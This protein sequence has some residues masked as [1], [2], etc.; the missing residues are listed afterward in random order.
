M[1]PKKL[2]KEAEKKGISTEGL[3]R[4]EII[5]KLR[6]SEGYNTNKYRKKDM[7]PK[8]VKEEAQKKG[9]STEGKTIKELRKELRISEGL[10]V[11]H[12]IKKLRKELREYDGISIRDNNQDPSKADINNVLSKSGEVN[13]DI[14]NLLSFYKNSRFTFVK[15]AMDHFL[16]N[17]TKLFFS[18][19]LK[20]SM[21]LCGYSLEIFNRNDCST[22]NEE[23]P[24]EN[25][26]LCAKIFRRLN[27]K[28]PEC[29]C[30]VRPNSDRTCGVPL[31]FDLYG[32]NRTNRILV[33]TTAKKTQSDDCDE[34]VIVEGLDSFEELKKWVHFSVTKRA[35]RKGL[36]S[37]EWKDVIPSHVADYILDNCADLKWSVE[38]RITCSGD[39]V[40]GKVEFHGLS[41]EDVGVGGSIRRRRLLKNR[42]SRMC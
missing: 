23:S 8:K 13:E 11:N 20:N 28:R 42:N 38:K 16:A 22:L 9:I 4:K 14:L 26:Q 34:E 31:N 29:V 33:K 32:K 37:I 7:K 21:C 5:R 3:K 2:K 17:D 1:K 10:H 19:N 25:I 35:Q 30:P 24:E 18:N 39:I 12:Q 6:E 36:N 41:Y 27:G 40:S 15:K